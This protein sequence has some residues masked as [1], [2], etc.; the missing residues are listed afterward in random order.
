MHAHVEYVREHLWPFLLPSQRDLKDR[1]PV[2]G[3]PITVSP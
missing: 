1:R 3:I 2:D